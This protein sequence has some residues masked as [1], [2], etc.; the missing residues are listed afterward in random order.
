MSNKSQI[1]YIKQNTDMYQFNFD[2]WEIVYTIIEVCNFRIFLNTIVAV[3]NISNE[4]CQY[5]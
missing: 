3:Q 4:W 1:A 2:V 5:I